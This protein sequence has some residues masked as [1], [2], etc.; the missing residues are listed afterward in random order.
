M[1]VVMADD[2]RFIEVQ[3]TAE[4]EPFDERQ[5]GQLLRLARAGCRRLMGIQNAA[6]RDWEKGT[7]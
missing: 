5:L 3:G 7:R 1:N 6:L 4:N 2:G